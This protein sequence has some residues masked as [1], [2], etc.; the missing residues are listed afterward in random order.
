MKVGLKK[1]IGKY[2]GI[3]KPVKASI[4]FTICS[5]LQKGI[6]LISTPI[7]T[8]LL[9]KEQYGVYTVYQ[10]W[11][12]IIIIF[13]TLNL[14]LG[15]YNNGMTKFPDDRKK[16]T[17]SM[18]GL[19]TTITALLFV[20]YICF[21][22]FW[23]NLLELNTLFMLAMFLEIL[24]VPAYSFWASGQRYDYK[25]R[26]LIVTT[27]FIAISSPLLGVIAVL[28]T[29]YKAEARVLSYV[30]VQ[31][32]IGLIFYIYN[33]VRGKKFFDKRYWKFALAFNL[34]LIP[35]YLSLT[36]L[37]Q[38]DRIMISRMVGQGEAAIYGVAYTTAMMM[39]IITNAI[40]H[41]FVPYT[42]KSMK[43]KQYDGIG[44]NANML[45]L[46]VFMLS[47]MANAFGPE[48]I[49]LFAAPSYY[50][51]RWVIPP[52]ATSLFFMFVYPLFGNIEFYFEQTK[53]IM[54]ASCVG[55]VTNIG[56]NYI[57]IPMFG[58]IAAAYTTL[59]CYMLFCVSHYFAHK[60]IMKKHGIKKSI[61]NLRIIF[62]LSIAVLM[63]MGIMTLLYDYALFRY[64]VI[65]AICV[66]AFIKRKYFMNIFSEIKKKKK[67]KEE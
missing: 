60:I 3:S 49:R 55:A 62:F 53:F 25:Y 51:A 39:T 47:V 42:Y 64:L 4:W 1:I 56:L 19:S 20:V 38:S 26:K 50:E 27:L 32:I 58:Y 59:F 10:S 22:N 21:H 61:Y 29:E 24:F 5:I 11:Y 30:L 45:L 36:V 67:G 54:V 31:I 46:L 7:F 15:V 34:P 6:S 16:F 17:S 63:V 52:V 43:Q 65:A 28:S 13:A 12:Q 8:N 41:S 40:N 14:Y 18:Q 48:I 33:F 57:F 9:T 44:R 2:N 35:H 66:V 37:S 23:N